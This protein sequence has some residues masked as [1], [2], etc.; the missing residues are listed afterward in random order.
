MMNQVNK[1]R[2][3]RWKLFLLLPV[4]FALVFAFA[5]TEKSDTKDISET[6]KKA[7]IS[8]E[9][10]FSEVDEMAEFPGGFMELR[11]FIAVN[12][13]YPEGAKLN[14]VSGKVLVQFVVNKEGKVVTKTDKYKL[15]GEDRLIEEVVVL[16]YKPAEGSNTENT[17]AYV[18]ELKD[19]A[20]RVLS[21]LPD[22]EKPAMINGKPVAVAFTMPINFALQ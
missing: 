9:T 11:K 2:K 8:T 5:C 15:Q 21:L 22:F 7:E 6:P 3:N 18:Q 20:V 19:E 1:G 17:E 10:A 4:S 12:L 16:A 13:K 14:G